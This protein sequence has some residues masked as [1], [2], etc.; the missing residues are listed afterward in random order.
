MC[1]QC[2]PCFA[3]Q[4]Q[5]RGIVLTAQCRDNLSFSTCREQGRTPISMVCV[6]VILTACRRRGCRRLMLE[7]CCPLPCDPGRRDPNGTRV[8]KCAVCSVCSLCK[9]FFRGFT[10]LRNY[11]ISSTLPGCPGQHFLQGWPLQFG[12]APCL[13]GACAVW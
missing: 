12:E 5:I 11:G 1:L 8:C 6:V 9:T 4:P 7:V 3:P 13:A 10:R 2:L